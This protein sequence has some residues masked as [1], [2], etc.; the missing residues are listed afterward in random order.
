MIERLWI[1]QLQP[2]RARRKNGGESLPI[3]QLPLDTG[4]SASIEQVF[5]RLVQAH[6]IHHAK[7][8]YQR[9]C[10]AKGKPQCGLIAA[11][12][13]LLKEILG[14]GRK[15]LFPPTPCRSELTGISILNAGRVSAWP[16]SDPQKREDKQEHLSFQ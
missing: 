11:Q 13:A 6:A 8:S 12:A 4:A 1:A 15:H 7:D 9:P 5:L 10:L 2:D 16:S 3:K 14:G